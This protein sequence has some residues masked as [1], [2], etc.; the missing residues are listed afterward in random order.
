MKSLLACWSNIHF[1]CSLCKAFLRWS[2]PSVFL[3]LLQYWPILPYA[4][5]TRGVKSVKS[6]DENDE[7]S[8]NTAIPPISW[9]SFAHKWWEQPCRKKKQVNDGK[10]RVTPSGKSWLLMLKSSKTYLFRWLNMKICRLNIH[11]GWL[12]I[13][14][15]LTENR[16]PN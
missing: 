2:F 4:K 6:V 15:G 3:V 1:V 14:V 16:L 10:N 12:G 5:H 13:Q 8:K 9:P 7:R 11:F